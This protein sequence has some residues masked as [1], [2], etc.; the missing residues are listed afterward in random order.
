MYILGVSGE[1]GTNCHE[2]SAS[3]WK[4]GRIVAAAEQERFSRRKHAY[5]EAA[6]DAVAFCLNKEKIGLDDVDYVAVNWEPNGIHKELSEEEEENVRNLYFP[7]NLFHY[8]K[9]IKCKYIKHHITHIAASFYQSG[10]SEAACLVIDGQ[11]ENEAI[12]LAKASGNKIE[13]IKTFPICCSLGAFYD[14]ATIYVGLG[15]NVAGKLMGLAPYGIPNQEKIISFDENTGEFVNK[16]TDLNVDDGFETTYRKYI[17]YFEKNCYPYNTAAHGKVTAEELMTYV[18]F[19]ASIQKNLDDVIIA[20]GR[21]L[22]KITKCDNLVM[23]GGVT[24]N[25]TSNGCLDRENIFENI[26]IYPPANDGGCSAGAAHELARELG[27]YDEKLPDRIKNVY[28]GQTYSD[29]DYEVAIHNSNFKYEHIENAEDFSMR[30]AQLLKDNKILGWVQEGFEYGPRA[31]GARSIICNPGCR[32][33]IN[34]VNRAKSRELWRPLSPIVLDKYYKQI[35]VDEKP[36]NMSEFM[37]KTCEIREEWIDR[38]PAVAHIDK[39]SRPQYLTKEAN[40]RMYDV[41]EK[42]YMLT[43]IPLLINTSFNIKAQPIVN[44]PREA[45][46]ALE[47]NEKLDGLIMGNWYVYR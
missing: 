9:K 3:L 7:K 11:G 17:K 43:G 41:L 29:M 34:K 30:V 40:P 19:A 18:N 16:V 15:D 13:I 20:M 4:D 22:K 27:L 42:F 14:A 6:Y 39:T 46:L 21:Y 5:G 28:L 38:I 32:E 47:T 1:P 45:L 44:S 8:T 10:F 12:T 24:L 36:Y 2:T 35:F 31:L 37:L 26:F 23:A 25:C 33:S